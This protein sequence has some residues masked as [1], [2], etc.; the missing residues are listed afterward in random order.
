MEE[1]G[2]HRGGRKQ[3]C[4]NAKCGTHDNATMRNVAPMMWTSVEV[5]RDDDGECQLVGLVDYRNR[6]TY[7]IVS[8]GVAKS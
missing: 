4:V 3:Q 5:V 1:L 7:H 6:A 8:L 2:R